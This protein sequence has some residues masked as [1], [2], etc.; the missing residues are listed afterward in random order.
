MQLFETLKRQQYRPDQSMKALKTPE[1]FFQLSFNEEGAYLSVIDHKSHEIDP[2]YRAYH[3]VTRD[4]LKMIQHIREKNSFL[5]SWENAEDTIYLASNEFLIWHLKHCPQ[6]VDGDFKTIVFSEQ[7]ASIDI[8]IEPQDDHFLQCDMTLVSQGKQLGSPQLISESYAFINRACYQIEPLGENFKSLPQFRSTIETQSLEKYLSLL[9]SFFSNVNVHYNNYQ[10]IQSEPRNTIA[11]L[12]F[13]KIDEDN[14]LYVRLSKTVA[15]LEADFLD[16]Y[17]INTI[18]TVNE[19]EETLHLSELIDSNTALNK[20]I[21]KRLTEHKKKLKTQEDNDYYHEDNLLIIEEALAKEFVHSDL[22]DLMQNYAVFGAEKLKSYKIK[23]VKPKLHLSL[24]HG[25]EFL[26][27]DAN[28]EIEGD[29]FDL[30]DV[31][32]QYRKNAYITLSDGTNALVSQSYIK[33]LERLF[34]KKKNKTQISFFDLPLLDE[35]IDDKIMQQS[36]SHSKE[37]FSGFNLLN[38]SR[39]KLPKVNA[40]LRPYQKQGFKWLNYLHTHKLGGCL[41]DDMGLGKTLQA[42]TLLSSIYPNQKLPSLI[43]MPKS[44]LYNW[45][46]E[47]KKFNPNLTHYVY[48]ANQRDLEVARQHHLIFTTYGMIRSDIEKFRQA[49]FYYVILDESQNIKNMNTQASKAVMLINSQ[50]RLALS[51]TPIENNLG[52]LYSLFRF[53]NPAM[54]GS[55]DEFNRYYA[56]PI[57]QE[58]DKNVI[59]E[60]KRKIYPFILRRLKKDVLKELPD[61]I[62]QIIYVDM[63]PPQQKL[64]E[65][66]RQYYYQAI[67][68]QVAK[69]GIKQS[70]FF[71]LQAMTELRQIASI[72]EVLTEGKITSPKREVMAEYLIDAIANKHK[73]LVFANYLG[74]IEYVGQDLQQQEIKHL[75]M[76]GATS[77]RQQLVDQFQNDIH[78]KVF[79]MTLKT[80]GLGLNLTAADNIFI[81]DPWWNKAAENQAIDRAH[82]MGQ[83][84]TVFSYKLIT[85]ATIEEKILKLQEMKS[86][87]FSSI[88][89]SDSASIKSLNEQDIEFMLG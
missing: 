54:F 27:G 38:K 65:Q 39:M 18:V 10:T 45:Q 56:S 26:E 20:I 3:G 47:I 48:Y 35:L 59:V 50:H 63:N 32:Q 86:E 16:D 75:V 89:S 6:L 49:D 87:L 23:I 52:E 60:L 82:R 17:D 11:S 70:Q 5:I 7:P 73:A 37:I 13:E 40:K 55:A 46:N 25:I 76:T 88:I 22:P 85:K 30:F 57:Q 8:H 84:K 14:S 41:A 71:I 9:Y 72:P 36:F 42:I 53:L 78:T 79:L 33:K 69:D 28:L 64:Y 15:G 34:K 12:I 31:I 77:H 80:G 29:R 58:A 67:K 21:E 2:D 19:M 51:G 66:R 74:A 83:D 44:L 24:G 43:I 62:E 68:S 81:F 1:V 61:K 4:I